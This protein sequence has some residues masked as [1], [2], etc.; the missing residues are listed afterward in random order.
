MQTFSDRGVP[1]Y[2][3]INNWIRGMID[4][5]RIKLGQ[6]LPTEEDLAKRFNVN[7]MTVRKAM[8][9][10]VADQMLIRKK[11]KGT[12]LVSTKP[13]DLIY[14]LENIT[15]FRDDMIGLG[16]KPFYEL[17]TAEAIEADEKVSEML[18]LQTN[19][20]VIYISRV[21][22][23]DNE[24]VLI[25]RN[26]LPYYEFKDIL[27]MDFTRPLFKEITERYNITL[28]HSTQTFSSV[29]SSDEETKLF[30]LSNPCPCFQLDCII[31]DPNNIP[32]IALF[33]YFRGDKYNLK[34][35]SGE[36]VA[37]DW[38]SQN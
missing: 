33:A 37:I 14:K 32:I 15:S 7:R 30:G 13:K 6:K 18:Q 38:D 23:A 34:F 26:Y 24:P 11:A 2:L 9:L 19:G 3:Q 17:L 1:K 5:G 12:F 8:D 21:L 31:S 36:Y 25:D 22:R 10:L 20:R 35:D 4:R 16:K 28:H 29:L 27:N